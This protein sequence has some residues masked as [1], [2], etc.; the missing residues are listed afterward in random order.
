MTLLKLDNLYEQGWKQQVLRNISLLIGVGAMGSATIL[1]LHDPTISW[2]ILVYLI[3]VVIFCG[4]TFFWG[5]R[6]IF[7]SALIL[8]GAIFLASVTLMEPDLLLNS[9]SGTSLLIPVC[10]M[11]LTTKFRYG[12][13]F[14]GLTLFTFAYVSIITGE[15]WTANTIS[16]VFIIINV[17]GLLWIVHQLIATVQLHNEHL[18]ELAIV[19][20]RNRIAHEIHDSLG[21]YLTAI[22]MQLRGASVVL[23]RDP[24][25]ALES[26]TEAQHMTKE[27]LQEVRHSID[28]LRQSPVYA[29]PLTDV[30]TKLVERNQA[31]GIPTTFSLIGTPRQLAPPTN[32][33]LYSAVQEGLTN[34][35]KH[36]QADQATVYLDYSQ[37]A[38]VKLMVEDNGQGAS[39]VNGGFGL[40]GIRERI[41]QLGG[42]VQI[43]T[44]P[45]HGFRMIIEVST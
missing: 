4:I 3:G 18:K 2:I 38:R 7:P 8:S 25:S 16:S 11:S 44:A 41:H 33:A 20:E 10:L 9:A 32:D 45:G 17:T 35:R 5:Y 13:V 42:S 34:I 21:H 28:A 39:S 23:T 40:I 15:P 37:A 19:N 1:Y 27:A 12:A 26:I 6:Y 14:S 36:A 30:L 24:D 31:A 43:M 29:R 22:N